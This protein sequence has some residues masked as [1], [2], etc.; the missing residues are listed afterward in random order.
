[1]RCIAAAIS[2]CRPG[3]GRPESIPANAV[4]RPR[5]FCW[6][7][8]QSAWRCLGQT[9]GRGIKDKAHKV[10]LSIKDVLGYPLRQ[11]FRRRLCGVPA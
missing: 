10:T 9:T 1:M 7:A 3:S 5:T 4:G 6:I 2:S 8:V 11:D